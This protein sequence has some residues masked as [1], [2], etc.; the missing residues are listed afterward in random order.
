MSCGAVEPVGRGDP[1]AV[2]AAR[3]AD[4][5]AAAVGFAAASGLRVAVQAHGARQSR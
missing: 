5:I 2:V 3:D 1:A 4:D